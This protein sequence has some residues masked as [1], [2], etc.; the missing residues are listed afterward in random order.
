MTL[1]HCKN[2]WLTSTTH[3]GCLRWISV[4][5]ECYQIG[6][7]KVCRGASS[8]VTLAN[9]FFRRPIWLHSCHIY[10]NHA[11]N[12]GTLQEQMNI[13]SKK[14]QTSPECW[15]G[16]GIA[17]F[18]KGDTNLTKRKKLLSTSISWTSCVVTHTKMS[19]YIGLPKE[20]QSGYM[21]NVPTWY[22][23][24]KTTLWHQT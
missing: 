3:L 21:G 9:L 16:F 22:L 18:L 11:C 17:G 8:L 6:L 24:I 7:L 10:H 20:W 12:Q 14:Q 13:T 23:Y 15:F 19:P 4:T 2:T 1:L 5:K